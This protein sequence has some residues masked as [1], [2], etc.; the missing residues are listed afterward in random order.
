MRTV[1]ITGASGGLAQ[2]MVKLLSNDQLILLGRDKEKLAQLYGNHP[3]AELIEI[4]IT[5]AQTIEELV[6]E[7]YQCYGKID[8]LINNAGY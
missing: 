5:D 3:Q 1:L 7:L 4:D 8:V 2:E 6:A